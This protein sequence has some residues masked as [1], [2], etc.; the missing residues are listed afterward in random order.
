MSGVVLVILDFSDIG[1]NL[2]EIVLFK[3]LF[4]RYLY[5]LPPKDIV[6]LDYIYINAQTFALLFYVQQQIWLINI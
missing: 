2:A 5:S 1:S 6:L 4:C 3:I